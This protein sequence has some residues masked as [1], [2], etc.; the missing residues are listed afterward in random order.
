MELKIDI[1]QKSPAFWLNGIRLETKSLRAD[2]LL[3]YVCLSPESTYQRDRLASLLWHDADSDHSRASLRQLIRRLKKTSALLNEMVEFGREKIEINRDSIRTDLDEFCQS[4]LQKQLD[5]P[6]TILSLEADEFFTD[7]VGFSAS[8]DAWIAIFRDRVETQLRQTLSSVFQDPS[9]PLV[10]REAAARALSGLDPTHEPS[11]R[12]LMQ[13]YAEHGDQGTAIR[14]YDQLYDRLDQDF[15]I[16]PTDETI[17][18][19]ADIKLGRL[20][21]GLSGT[22]QIKS[23][24]LEQETVPE[25]VVEGFEL[26]SSSDRTQMIAKVLRYELLAKLSTF[27]EWRLFDVENSDLT[28]YR[29]EGLVSEYD[30]EIVLI[31]TLKRRP[32]ERIIW[33]ERFQISYANWSEAQVLVSRRIALAVNSGVG[34]DRL[35][36]SLSNQFEKQSTFD[37]WILAQSLILDWKPKESKQGIAL[38]HEILEEVPRFAPAHASLAMG[39]YLQHITLPGLLRDP[40]RINR[41]LHHAQLALELDPLDTRAHLSTAWAYA[42]KGQHDMG[43]FHFEQCLGLGPNS[44]PGRMSCALG[45]AFSGDLSGACKIVDETLEMSRTLPP[46]LWGYAQNIWFLDHRLDD[47]ISA[48]ERA[49]ASI[50]NLPAWQAA[51]YWE[52]G[53]RAEA[54][55]AAEKFAADVRKNWFSDIPCDAESITD[56]FVGCFPLKAEAQSLRLRN[57][58][59]SALAT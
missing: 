35:N 18:L 25:I 7:F 15:D 56:W 13:L 47:A 20:D 29:L 30:D 45:Y 8:F 21:F 9:F 37:K 12:F 42:M 26:G 41:S 22:S 34:N 14:L 16:E 52:A 44:I 50:S 48:G 38:L 43:K 23:M 39:E 53:R 31:A 55:G 49:G 10:R 5:D 1:L 11:C 19:I 17:E 46:Y 4:H 57:G 54:K 3:L 40:D 58:L 28:G 36:A 59:R 33:S 32:E 6:I 2:A 27:R 51:A 24:Q